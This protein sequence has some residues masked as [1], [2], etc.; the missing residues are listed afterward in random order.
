MNIVAVDPKWKG[1]KLTTVI[2]LYTPIQIREEKY[3][4]GKEIE[5]GDSRSH[6][7][8]TWPGVTSLEPEQ[9]S[10][11]RLKALGEGGAGGRKRAPYDGPRGPLA[12]CTST[13]SP[14][15]GGLSCRKTTPLH[16][17]N[18]GASG[19]E[20]LC[21]VPWAPCV[22][23]FPTPASVLRAAPLTDDSTLSRVVF[24]KL[25]CPGDKG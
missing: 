16:P 17:Q 21:T 18:G 22:P 3:K 10:V 24:Q 13:R 8:V 2:Q 23:Y 15:P 25:V 19:L 9:A 12:I 11:S 14:D 5:N 4:K 1:K 6:A 7:A 20:K